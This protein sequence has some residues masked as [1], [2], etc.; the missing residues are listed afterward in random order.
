VRSEAAPTIIPFQGTLG[1][2]RLQKHVTGRFGGSSCTLSGILVTYDL[3]T[4]IG[5]LT[6]EAGFEQRR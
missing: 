1:A 3:A 2:H 5:P 6:G 4:P